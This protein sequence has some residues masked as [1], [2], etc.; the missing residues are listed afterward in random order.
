MCPVMNASSDLQNM[1]YRAQIA[2]TWPGT[3][4][5]QSMDTQAALQ[6][7][8]VAIVL[9]FFS[10]FLYLLV[11]CRKLGGGWGEGNDLCNLSFLAH[12]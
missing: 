1:Y 12:L 11:Q 10:L 9:G 5:C 3:E 4:M 7:L 8:F 6:A 2:I